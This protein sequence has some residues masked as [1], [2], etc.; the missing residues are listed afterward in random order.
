MTAGEG[1]PPSEFTVSFIHVFSHAGTHVDAPKH[2]GHAGDVLSLPLE[3]LN[4]PAFVLDVPGGARTVGRAVLEAAFPPRARAPERLL[5]R[6]RHSRA[7]DMH[8]AEF[9]AGYTALDAS[10]ARWIAERGV[11]LVG[12]DYLSA[13]VEPDIVEG[14]HAL[15]S[16]GVV[17]LEGLDLLLPGEDLSGGVRGSPPGLWATLP[18][19]PDTLIA[20]MALLT[21][22]I[23]ATRAGGFAVGLLMAPMAEQIDANGLPSGGKLIG[24]LERGLIYVMIL[25]GQPAGIGFLIAAKSVLRFEATSDEKKAE[26]VIIGTLASFGWA[27]ITAYTTL[28]ALAALR[29]LA[30]WP[31]LS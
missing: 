21:G 28:W 24:L 14:H 3:A 17:L 11:R 20:M 25:A 16:A 4:G 27:M 29:P 7:G 12:V 23:I 15:L 8:R 6:T 26:Y 9:Q 2:V 1:N 31:S 22:A 5:L 13:V 30:I 19:L 10:G 18:A